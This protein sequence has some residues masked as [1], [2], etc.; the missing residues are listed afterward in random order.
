MRIVLNFLHKP[1]TISAKMSRTSLCALFE[2]K[3]FRKNFFQNNLII[4]CRSPYSE[5]SYDLFPFFFL[6]L[7]SNSHIFLSLFHF[8]DTAFS[9]KTRILLSEVT[10]RMHKS[11]KNSVLCVWGVTPV[12]G[13][14]FFLSKTSES[15]N[16]GIILLTD[17]TLKF[18]RLKKIFYLGG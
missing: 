10:P 16:R 1:S 15:V 2:S 8:T 7:W 13:L 6:F 18:N 9:K 14:H 12:N 3:T 5:F 17:T 11:E 4:F